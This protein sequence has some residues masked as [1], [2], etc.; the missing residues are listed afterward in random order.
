MC[1]IKMV[2]LGI[3][4]ALLL[5]VIALILVFNYAIVKYYT[6][7]TES[8]TLATT[9]TVISLTVTLIAVLLIPIDIYI[10][11]EDQKFSGI[12]IGKEHVRL[13]L[14]SVFCTMVFLS[15]IAIPF[16][17]FYGEERYDEI[18]GDG[19]LCDKVCTASKYTFGFIIVCSVLILIG[20]IFRPG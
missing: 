5:G 14:L 18:D 11:T 4:S 10:S 13:V 20:L 1:S 7:A 17:Y 2:L 9:I 19:S 15:F 8:Y 16:T 12:L 3:G 6:D